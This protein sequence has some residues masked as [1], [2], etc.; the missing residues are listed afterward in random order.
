VHTVGIGDPAA[1]GEQRVDLDLL[2]RMASITGGRAF[3]GEDQAGLSAIYATLDKLT[4]HNEKTLSW[5][6]RRELY[7]WPL[8]AA[9]LLVLAYQA[10]MALYAAWLGRRLRPAA[11]PASAGQE[12][13]Q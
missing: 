12:P 2:K 4:P 6:A 7:M 8:G 9:V 5:R 3:F 10:G 13:A 11:A 1:S